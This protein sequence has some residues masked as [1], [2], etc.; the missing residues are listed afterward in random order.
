ME[1]ANEARRLRLADMDFS[2]F[3]EGA[4]AVIFADRCAGRI[5][6][7]FRSRPEEDHVRQVFEAEAGAYEMAR[8]V[9]ELA[10]LIPGGF[11]RCH[12]QRVVDQAGTDVSQEFFTDLAFEADFVDATF[13]KAG[14]VA[15][16]DVRRVRG[17]LRTAGI[18][19]TSDMSVAVGPDGRI[20]KIIDFA[21]EEHELWHED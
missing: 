3:S 14:A 17:L 19:H 5:R 9:P 6:K 2:Y 13:Q 4:Y 1:F 8:K 16:D 21:I 20:F 15:G 11:K 18:N 12:P 10:V 7:L